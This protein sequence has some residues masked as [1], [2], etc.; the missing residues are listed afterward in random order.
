[1]IYTTG[2]SM[3]SKEFIKRRNKDN[4]YIS[5]SFRG[6]EL[7]E[8]IDYDNINNILNKKLN[9]L[10]D[11]NDLYHIVLCIRNIFKDFNEIFL[12]I[13][14]DNKLEHSV[15]KYQREEI[16]SYESKSK[17]A[18]DKYFS[19]KYTSDNNFNISILDDQNKKLEYY[20]C[21]ELMELINRKIDYLSKLNSIKYPDNEKVLVK[22]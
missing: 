1:M 9:K 2:D 19:F 14:Y 17:L 10:I 8:N 6:I 15:I 16:K 7:S 22:K 20:F 4:K 21:K 13:R 11:S 12:E 3:E 18:K 5:L